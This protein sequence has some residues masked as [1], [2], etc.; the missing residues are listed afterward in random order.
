MPLERNLKLLLVPLLG[1]SACI[2][3]P[4]IEEELDLGSCGPSKPCEGD[5]RCEDGRCVAVDAGGPDAGVADAAAADTGPRDTGPRDTGPRD[6]APPD[7]GRLGL[8]M[9]VDEAFPDRSTFGA[10]GAPTHVEDDACP[11]RAG[12]RRGDCHRFV[13]GASTAFTGTFWT[14]GADYEDLVAPSIEPGAT[15]VRFFAWGSA[16]G[17]VIDFG[18][19]V[20]ASIF[21]GASDQSTITLT[22][23][24]APYS[25]RLRT[26]SDYDRIFGGFM[27]AANATSNPGGLEYF[28][29]DIHW[30]VGP[31]A[32]LPLPVIVDDYFTGRSVFSA[33]GDAQLHTEDDVCPSRGG[34]ARGE[35]HRIRW[36]AAEDYAGAHWTVGDRFTLLEPLAV[37]AG[38][39]RLRFTA[40]GA[41]GGE[42]VEI[43]AGI[44]GPQFDG[45]EEKLALVLT[46]T[47]TEYTVPL[48]T[49]PTR[50]AV[51]SGFFWAANTT[52]NG[53]QPFEFYLDDIRW[54]R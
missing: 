20:P 36:D 16:G 1:A 10:D 31:P 28:V 47:P 49:L 52:D 4:A 45:V 32:R 7:A 41:A 17:E 33:N 12:E 42:A 18:I 22:A 38:A 2:Y 15:E 21:D 3:G 51:Y 50:P 53:S 11:R 48:L 34:E 6:A 54:I 19:G 27:W 37:E 44:S 23:S 14:V 29:D 39:T 30:R 5:L 24:P 46:S 8:P 40:W 35:C 26:L 13:W 9:T 25:V 43:G